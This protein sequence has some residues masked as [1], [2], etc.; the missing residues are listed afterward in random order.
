M[1]RPAVLAW[2]SFAIALALSIAAALLLPAEA[3]NIVLIAPFGVVGAL[4]A[5]RRP[6]HR[7]GWILCSFAVTFAVAVLTKAYASA[8]LVADHEWPAARLAAWI[9]TWFWLV[10]VTQLE[11]A[12]LLFPSGRFAGSRWRWLALAIIIANALFGAGRALMPGPL[13]GHP[14]DNPF[15]VAALAPA[16]TGFA[17]VSSPLFLIGLLISL[18]SPFV[19][20]PQMPGVEREQVKWV[21]SGGALLA[22]AQLLSG[23]LLRIGLAPTVGEFLSHA[24]YALGV[25]AIP[26][27]MGVA[28]LR[29][30]MYDIEVI[31]RRT[32]IYGSMLAVL[33]A[34]YL[35]GVVL[36]QSILRGFTSGSEIA[37]AA[38]TLLTIALFQP[39]RSRIQRGIDRRFYRSRYD[40]ARTIDAFAEQLRDEV[41]L[42]AV[43]AHLLATVGHTVAPVHASV[44][45]RERAR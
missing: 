37:V 1:R 44:W 12:F 16:A 15:G 10:Y 31:I 27:T 40:A 36:V 35:G 32:L 33:A 9:Y 23:L 28:I 3:F 13:E 29:Y 18:G 45:L 2:A 6:D 8:G 38:S 21:A 41:D 14:I 30:R 43:R 7:I 26:A 24:L 5:S 25:V 11:L 39:L 34:A 17:A 4:L 20:L 19:R 42:E 22:V